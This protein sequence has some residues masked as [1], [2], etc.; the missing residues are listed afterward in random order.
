MDDLDEILS[1]RQ[2]KSW[3]PCTNWSGVP[4]PY[5]RKGPPALRKTRGRVSAA[6]YV[7]ALSMPGGRV[8]IGQSGNPANRARQLGGILLGSIPVARGAALEVEAEALRM[9]G[10]VA[11]EGETA[12]ASNA[13][14]LH[15][16][17]TAY[18]D[19][20]RRMHVDPTISAE[21][22]RRQ[23]IAAYQAA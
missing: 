4:Q 18:A 23:R 19:V 17:A 14:A 11:G 22:A 16:I 1:Q 2:E 5:R 3:R 13:A 9:L 20:G 8:K 21:E 15:A 7:Y 10:A 6:P 12:I